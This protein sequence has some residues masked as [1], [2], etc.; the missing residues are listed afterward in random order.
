MKWRYLFAGSVI[1][2]AMIAGLFG[3][4]ILRNQAVP[5]GAADPAFEYYTKG[6]SNSYAAIDRWAHYG[7]RA[8]RFADVLRKAG[9]ACQQPTVLKDEA[10]MGAIRETLCHK[11]EQWPLSR[12]LSIRASIEHGIVARLVG[13]KASSKLTLDDQPLTKRLADLLRKVGWMEPD[14]LQVA[15]FQID[16]IETLS[17]MV[18]DTLSSTGWYARCTDGQL[19]AQCNQ[20]TDDRMKSGF[21]ALP[22]GQGTLPTGTSLELHRA[23]ERIGFAPVQKRGADGKPE[24]SLLVRPANGRMWLDFVS[25]DLGGRDLSASIELESKGGTPINLVTG[26]N[27]KSES[28]HLAGRPRRA[29][30]DSL[31]YLLPEAGTH[32]ARYSVWLNLPNK[33]FPGTFDQLA[34]N[35]PLV[36]AAFIPLIVK[37]ISGDAARDTSPEESLGLYPVLRQMEQK[38]EVFRA[39][40]PDRWLPREHGNRLI[41]QA[42]PEDPVIRAAWAFATCEPLSKAASI[43]G[44]C[45]LRF[46]TAD[47]DAAALVRS[48]IAKQQLLYGDLPEIHPL[49][50]RLKHLNEAFSAVHHDEPD[51]TDQ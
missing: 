22:Q 17:R 9:Y 32:H 35:L 43:D 10:G 44:N 20:M 50:T 29:N 16:S 27:G 11:T 7:M 25:K 38:A 49:R 40:H 15:G 1:L 42:Y 33:N 23:M 51:S 14:T 19:G 28:I 21:P 5:I 46:T 24:D 18:A 34:R 31:V 4:G 39:L 41:T 45:L 26:L 36:D 8:E 48:E 6:H 47:P 13:A 2:A 3:L 37:A 30:D 12:T